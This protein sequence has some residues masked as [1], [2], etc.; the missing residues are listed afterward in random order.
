MSVKLIIK[1]IG[2]LNVNKMENIIC[3]FK[4]GWDALNF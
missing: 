2:S 3:D 4:I 1:I